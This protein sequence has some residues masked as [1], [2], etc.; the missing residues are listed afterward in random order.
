[1][2]ALVI[3]SDKRIERGVVLTHSE[4]IELSRMAEIAAVVDSHESP[5]GLRCIYQDGVVRQ[6]DRVE[7][8]IIGAAQPHRGRVG[9]TS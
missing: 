6:Y 3:R 9:W 4:A 7:N 8:V 5:N 2:N 1:M